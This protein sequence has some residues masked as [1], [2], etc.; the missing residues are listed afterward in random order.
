MKNILAIFTLV[1]AFAFAANAQTA[2]TSQTAN[3]GFVGY[4]FLRQNVE[5]NRASLKFDTD[6]DSHG[7]NAGYTR[8]F[9]GSSRKAGVVGFTADLGANFDNGDASLVTVMG[10]LVAKAR[11][12]KY[13]QPY[14]RAMGGFSRQN[15]N[16][17]NIT[18]TSDITSAFALGTG[19]DINVKKYSRYKIR[20]GADYLNTGFKGERQ[21]SVRLTTGLVF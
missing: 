9:G 6:T 15:V 10:G 13:V 12:G 20:F 8:Y 21:N 11:N 16:R 4:S 17:Y 1:F 5:V 3:E 7:F 18:D 19:L 14:V 2:T